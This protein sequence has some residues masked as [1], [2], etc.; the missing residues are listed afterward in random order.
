MN[1]RV[2][3]ALAIAWS[4]MVSGCASYMS[5]D[6]RM[7]EDFRSYPIG[8]RGVDGDTFG[9]WHVVFTGYGDAR[10]ARVGGRRALRLTTIDS[11]APGDTHAALVVGPEFAGSLDV[12]VSMRTERQL[13]RPAVPNPWEVAWF[14]FQYA[15]DAHF[16][17][18]IPKPNG[19]ELGKRDPAYPGGQRF[20]ASGTTPVY[21]LGQWHDVRLTIG[22]VANLTVWVDGVR[23]VSFDDKERPYSRGRIAFYLE[24]AT[25]AFTDLQLR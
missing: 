7:H 13:R 20:L 10:I 16:Y 12:R 5:S 22:G 11:T 21:S 14:V 23:V 8:W 19:W 2:C 6:I 18:F 1:A 15:D 4:G 17:Y 25:A 24:D 9:P 3:A